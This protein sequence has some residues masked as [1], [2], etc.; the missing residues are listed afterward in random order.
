M[1]ELLAELEPLLYGYNY[2]VFLRAYRVTCA[3]GESVE[4]LIAQ[5]LGPLAVVGNVVPVTGHGVLVEV[6]QCLRYAGDSGSGP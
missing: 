5:A 4:S 2:Q 3:P 1:E 6:E